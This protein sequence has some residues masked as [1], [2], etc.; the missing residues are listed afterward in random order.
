VHDDER[1]GPRT[2]VICVGCGVHVLVK[3]NSLA[4]TM[5]QWRTRADTCRA[6]DRSLPG[7][8]RPACDLLRRSIDDAVRARRLLV[9]ELDE[10]ISD[11]RS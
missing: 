6:A 5:V 7:A 8:L 10:T 2:P 1:E 3:K 4:H 11:G 9:P